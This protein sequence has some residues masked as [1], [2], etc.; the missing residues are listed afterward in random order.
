MSVTETITPKGE[1]VLSFDTSSP[2]GQR[3]S[4][5]FLLYRSQ[6][7]NPDW[8]VESMLYPNSTLVRLFPTLLGA[9]DDG[10]AAGLERWLYLT[11]AL[12]T[13]CVGGSIEGYRQH[14]E[15]MGSLN[16]AINSIW[17]GPAWGS[18]SHD[19]SWKALHY[20]L[21]HVFRPLLLSFVQPSDHS[22]AAQK[23]GAATN[24]GCP[25]GM[26]CLHLSNHLPDPVIPHR[27]CELH[28]RR[29]SDGKSA[30]SVAFSAT[31]PG[32]GG[33]LAASFNTANLFKAA[34]CAVTAACW[35]S[36]D[37]NTEH[38]SAAHAR[39]AHGGGGVVPAVSVVEAV[40]FPYGLAHATLSPARVTVSE[41]A[42]TAAGNATNELVFSVS[43]TTV[44]P[45]TFFSCALPGV[46]SDNTLTLR[47]M[48][49][50]IVLRFM[51]PSQG[52]G[53]GG[54]PSFDAFRKAT[55]VY[56][57]NNKMPQHL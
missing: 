1:G 37:C 25:A 31:A 17:I 29:F 55:R 28:V 4:S 10:T 53:P 44:A 36:A 13:R 38:T 3:G 32:V 33:G 34:G 50:P 20:R 49:T 47:P 19:G 15:V 57:M 40:D 52:W 2:S 23:A 6:I 54:L 9:A 22:A 42:P 41:V 48:E 24:A 11:Q 27:R 43:V 18:I 35:L 56:T 46:F 5:P 45:Y 39:A 21:R 30:K 12:Q 16:W 7:K 8:T 51:E 26:T 14:S